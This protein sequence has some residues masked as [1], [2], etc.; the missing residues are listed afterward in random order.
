MNLALNCWFFS[1]LQYS[2]INC[3]TVTI[4]FYLLIIH[5]MVYNRTI[6]RFIAER[7]RLFFSE[8]DWDGRCDWLQ[9]TGKHD[10]VWSIWA[11]DRGE[12][13]YPV[14][15][16]TESGSFMQISRADRCLFGLSSDWAQ[17]PPLLRDEQGLPLPGRRTTV[18]VLQ[19]LF[20]R[21]SMLPSFQ[22]LS[23]NS[24]NSLC[25]SYPFDR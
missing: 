7:V 23:G 19:I 2:Y 1:M 8:W 25:G 20:S 18:P 10:V 15:T 6:T 17:G 22:P 24:L 11:G 16:W 14:H 4:L 12:V 3:K 13:N 5:L 21:L 9:T